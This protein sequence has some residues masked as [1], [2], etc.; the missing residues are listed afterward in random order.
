MTNCVNVSVLAEVCRVTTTT[1]SLPETR[2][3]NLP[4]SLKLLCHATHSIVTVTSAK[5]AS[6]APKNHASLQA[7]RETGP[8]DKVLALI[9]LT[10]PFQTLPYDDVL[11]MNLVL[12]KYVV[13]P[14][15]HYPVAVVTH[16][17]PRLLATNWHRSSFFHPV[18]PLL[19][20]LCIIRPGQ[21]ESN[22]I[23]CPTPA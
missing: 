8:M 13:L 2:H 17:L 7:K 11:V 20:L 22:F 21:R 18:D 4:Q 16:Y 3:I 1:Q 15:S 14:V 12:V 19:F 9:F 23:Q 5:V 6:L 10:E